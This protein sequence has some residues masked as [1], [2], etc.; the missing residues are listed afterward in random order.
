MAKILQLRKSIWTAICIWLGL[1]RGYQLP[2]QLPT[3]Y[4]GVQQTMSLDLFNISLSRGSLFRFLG[5]QS[6]AG[7][8]KIGRVL[9]NVEQ[10]T[11]AFVEPLQKSVAPGI[12]RTTSRTTS[13]CHST[14]P[15]PP[16][17]PPVSTIPT[18]PPVPPVSCTQVTE[19]VICHTILRRT[20]CI[21]N[22]CCLHNGGAIDYC[23]RLSSYSYTSGPTHTFPTTWTTWTN[24]CLVARC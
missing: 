14:T 4:M 6:N 18:A 24:T 9:Y 10:P 11:A 19:Q 5:G 7:A 13:R 22:L 3:A 12:I 2:A 21:V 23:T 16:P 1:L 17:L 20:H 15:A 8:V